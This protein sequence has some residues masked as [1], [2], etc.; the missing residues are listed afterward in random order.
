MNSKLSFWLR[1]FNIR[2]DEKT[3]VQNL[4]LHHFFLGI[5][6]ALMFTVASSLFLSKYSTEQLPFAFM[7]SAAAMMVVGRSYS[8]FEHKLSIRK[9]LL[10]VMGAM[11]L[12]P[13]L[14][15]STFYFDSIGY[16]PFIIIIGERVFYLLS[17][18]EFWCMSSIVFDVRQGKRLFGLISSGDIPA[19]LL[20]YLSVSVLEPIVGINNLL[21]LAAGSILLASLFLRKILLQPDINLQ[22]REAPHEQFSDKKLLINFFGNQYILVLSGMA[23]LTIACF[24]LIDFTFLNNVQSTFTTQESLAKY[25]ST[26]LAIGYA[27]IILVKLLLS[28]RLAEQTGI[29]FSL[30]I[31]PVLLFLFSLGFVFW[32]NA[33]NDVYNNLMYIGIMFMTISVAKYSVNDPVFLAMFQPLPT[34][35]RLKG[36]TIIKG[37]VQPLALGVIGL[38]LWYV[39][40]VGDHF[41]FY[42]LNLGILI[43]S[44]L[45]IYNISRSHK[46]YISTLATAIRNRFISG[47]EIAMESA[48][49]SKL[50]KDSIYNHQKEDIIYGITALDEKFP[51]VLRHE[52]KFVL[53]TDSNS[54]RRVALNILN[55][56]RWNEYLGEVK[57]I[58]LTDTH[59]ET[60]AAAAYFCAQAGDPEIQNSI[61]QEIFA[62]LPALVQESIFKGILKSDSM[63]QQQHA[64]NAIALMLTSDDAKRQLTAITI[65]SQEYIP[66]FESE[67]FRLMASKDESVM[68]AAIG[69]AGKSK[70]EAFISQLIA[71]L[72]INPGAN[73][74]IESLSNYG[75]GIFD[76]LKKIP[77]QSVVHKQGVLSDIIRI[78]EISPG[79]KGGQFLFSILHHT[80][81]H[82]KERIIEVL[83][84]SKYNLNAKEKERMERMLKE[85]IGFAVALLEGIEDPALNTRLHEAF[86]FDYENCKRRIITIA[87]LL[88]NR[89]IMREAAAAFRNNSKER[90][91]NA[92]EIME[93]VIPRKTAQILVVLLDN[94]SATQKVQKL[95][96][97]HI[98]RKHEIPDSI[99]R[100]GTDIYSAWTVCLALRSAAYHDSNYIQA[101][102]IMQ[103]ENSLLRESAAHYLANFKENHPNHFSTLAGTFKT[104]IDE[105]MKNKH[106]NTISDFEK[107]LVLKGTAL[108]GGTPENIIAEIIPIVREVRVN[109][110]EVIF[111]KGDS[112]SSMYIIYNGEVKIHDGAKT[113]ATLGK[114]EF[115]GELALLDPEPR[116][117]SA[118]ATTDTL[119]L[120]LE[121]EEA[122]E[123]MEERTEV[124]R[125]ILRIL[126]RRIRM[127]NDKLVAGTV[128]KN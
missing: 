128:L 39:I 94:I 41:D 100:D 84:I 112:G 115:F 37:F 75:D 83:S 64:I 65:L 30:L 38:I 55:R 9:L 99:L 73:Y 98:N 24:T 43:L 20:G 7:L 32:S 6:Q 3:T 11:V 114:R 97:F 90:R 93:Q 110:G 52:M 118:T 92:L 82:L 81:P 85:E 70:S 33:Q 1:L 29:K 50:L 60:K 122:Y 106:E 103:T 57:H 105:I 28:G 80:P 58:Y 54:V 123:L 27:F 76:H 72:L 89:K 15:R 104:N 21:W 40:H 14:L 47:S 124:L 111:S 5:G 108:F 62:T 22:V 51:D 46:L 16:I 95:Q 91:A 79:H 44:V 119:L 35:L 59:L 49:F 86:N 53:T 116:S 113:F 8:F 17:N 96:S 13:F 71:L 34:Q 56:R 19:K 36:H 127:Q 87:G 102:N 10:M 125:S 63:Q 107:V 74:I 126:C 31:M 109:A 78:A 18:L 68:I 42:L 121:E 23:F 48:S 117:A 2:N 77:F 26:F 120:K 12:I 67:I 66:Q 69:A 4:V 45:W 61:G 25:I 101:V 88:Y